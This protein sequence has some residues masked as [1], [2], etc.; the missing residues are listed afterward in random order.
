MSLPWHVRLNLMSSTALRVPD[1]D[2]GSTAADPPPGDDD[3]TPEDPPP[4]GTDGAPPSETPPVVNNDGKDRQ[5]PADL[6]EQFWDPRKGEIR[7]DSLLKSYKDTKAKVG[8]KEDAMRSRLRDEIMAEVAPTDLPKEAKD[9]ALT[10]DQAKL[11]GDDDPLL[12]A[13]REAAHEAKLSPAA[14]QAIVG[15]V[16]AANPPP[17]PA[18]ETAKLGSDADARIDRISRFVDKN[19]TDTA[20]NGLAK[21]LASTADGV[22]L[23][24]TLIGIKAAGERV[25]D[26]GGVNPQSGPSWSEI[27]SAMNDDRYQPG[28]MQ[29]PAYVAQ[30]DMMKDRHFAASGRRRAARSGM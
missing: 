12:S 17:D 25:G 9:Y 6:P 22:R 30:V 29:D 10:E 13:F 11:V 1:D 27:K 20:L 23:I 2:T 7:M 28:P 8:E 3:D 21:T 5:R 4:P 24:E 18:A 19:V 14:F 15:K 26:G 16:L